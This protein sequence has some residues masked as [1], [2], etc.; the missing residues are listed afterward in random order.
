M[1][2]KFL[3]ALGVFFLAC[4]ALTT[5]AAI[6][7]PLSPA[8]AVSAGLTVHGHAELK[9]MPDIA[10]LSVSVTTQARQQANASQDNAR[11]MTAILSALHTA[12]VADKDIQTSGYDTSPQYDYTPSPPVLT[13][14]QVSNTLDVTVR[15]LKKAGTIIDA[16][17]QAGATNVGGLS[18]DLSD[19]TAAEQQAL[20]QAVTEAKAKA[21]AMAQAAGVGRGPLLSLSE[22]APTVVQPLIM[23]RSLMA[24][25]APAMPT[26]PVEAHEITITADVTAVYQILQN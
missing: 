24:A 22:G 12:G 3:C 11:R 1:T 26:T 23:A 5:Q 2:I 13:G 10:H 15:N 18:F 9:V 14:Y 17:T 8:S 25:A 16:V 4:C 21:E 20:S 19:R 7:E 6:I